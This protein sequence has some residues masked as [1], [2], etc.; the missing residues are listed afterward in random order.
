[1]ILEYLKQRNTLTPLEALHKFGCLR[2]GARV[3]ELK[4]RGYDIVEQLVETEGGKHVA[5]YRLAT[6]S[7]ELKVSSEDHE[8][9]DLVENK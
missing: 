1:M 5:E 8:R 9:A 7:E 2:L 3:W 6:K 4:K